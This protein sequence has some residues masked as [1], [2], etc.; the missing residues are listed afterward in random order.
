MPEGRPGAHPRSRGEN[1][2]RPC[3]DIPDQGSS[4]LTRGKHTRRRR[5]RVRVGL[6]PAHAGKTLITRTTRVIAR[7]HP[8]SRGENSSP[9][10]ERPRGRGSSP[11]TRGKP[12]GIL[13]GVSM[14]GLI[15]AH[16]GKT[17]GGL[18]TRCGIGAHP[19]SRGENRG[20]RIG[21]TGLLGS[22]PLTRGKLPVALI[23]T[24]SRG[25]IPA[26]AGKTD[27][28]EYACFSSGAHPR[29]RG[30]N[31]ARTRA[32]EMVAGSS[33]L[34]R[35]KRDRW[36]RGRGGPGL[37]PAHAGK[38]AGVF[39]ARAARWAHPR[40]RG[41]NK[42]TDRSAYLNEGSSPLTRG[43][44]QVA[45]VGGLERGLIPAHAG[46]TQASQRASTPSA[47]HP[48]SRGENTS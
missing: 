32:G 2:R 27:R 35:G 7:A 18:S 14:C 33:P 31:A 47:A 28:C 42:G 39:S 30:E 38:T 46:K 26:H 19:R 45:Q 10:R 23:A 48:R 12:D 3:T 17:M 5:R 41:E 43:K 9:L 6:I 37:I 13:T 34:T 36:C 44:P 16:A 4:P 25:L 11:L 40:S 1:N 15:P 8:R 22:S 24:K 29:S 21:H 20:Q